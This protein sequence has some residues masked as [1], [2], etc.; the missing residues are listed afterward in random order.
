[1]TMWSPCHHGSV[2]HNDIDV[3]QAVLP[4]SR[5]DDDDDA[6]PSPPPPHPY[7]NVNDNTV[8]LLPPPLRQR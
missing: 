8:S 4:P 6:M 7:V 1:M 3:P 5:D 2:S